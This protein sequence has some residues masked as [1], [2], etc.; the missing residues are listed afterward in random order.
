MGRRGAAAATRRLAKAR[1]ALHFAVVA[2]ATALAGFVGDQAG[3]GQAAANPAGSTA[4]QAYVGR[5][6][7]DRLLAR[8]P[9]LAP[10]PYGPGIYGY[11]LPM[12]L[13]PWPP[14]SPL[15][16]SH[17]GAFRFPPLYRPQAPVVPVTPAP[18]L[19]RPSAQTAP[20]SLPRPVVASPERLRPPPTLPRG[21]AR[22]LT[23]F[24]PHA[25]GAVL[26]ASD[27]A[28][29]HE[30]SRR[31]AEALHESLLAK[32]DEDEEE[33]EESG[34][35]EMFAFSPYLEIEFQAESNFD[36]DGSDDDDR[37]LF[38]PVL[39]FE[40]EFYP[41]DYFEAF[42]ELELNANVPLLDEF[43]DQSTDVALSLSE[44]YGDFIYPLDDYDLFVRLGRQRYV[45][46]REWLYDDNLDAARLFFGTDNTWVEISAVYEGFVPRDIWNDDSLDSKR[47][48]ANYY[49]AYVKHK[50][51]S[52]LD[53]SAFVIKREDKEF[54]SST[55]DFPLYLGIH[56]DGKFFDRRLRTWL[57]F[58]HVRGEDFGEDIDAYGFDIGGRYTFDLPFEPRVTLGYAFGTGDG[59]QGDG[60][61]RDFRQTGLQGNQAS[62]GGVTGFEYYGVLLDPE[63][64]NLHIPTL[65]VGISPTPESSL[66]IV[67]HHYR[68]VEPTD[69]L[70]D[71]GIDI[72]PDGFERTVGN[73]IDVVAG[74][75]FE[76]GF[77]IE[78]IF[79]Y[80]MPGNAF[81]FD[82][83]DAFSFQLFLD[84]AL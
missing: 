35:S 1:R 52:E 73:E 22:G 28:G 26:G 64:S 40:A 33:L 59:N 8:P 7:L 50:P 78:A 23:T 45:D 25:P 24:R 80:F 32:H 27:L 43:G 9:A 49:I 29:P 44:A 34:L 58:A 48:R 6:T 65:G 10:G 31:T 21:D 61:A 83:E 54:N 53:L 42:L 63:L 66:D 30:L 69:F 55:G 2:A 20:P 57:E 62:F 3:L 13:A 79:A 81:D 18:L 77:E 17:P 19:T 74:Y 37:I 41:S 5:G 68:Q 15:H 70:F 47:D 82:A 51:I 84:Y 71:S 72:D 16:L 46:D 75:E 36:L 38:F 4:S 14:P 67:Y 56:S 76:N 11:S 60:E 12:P 39:G